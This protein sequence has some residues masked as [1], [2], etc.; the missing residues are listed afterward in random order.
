MTE[1]ECKKNYLKK[2]IDYEKAEKRIEFQIEELRR[3]KMNPSLNIDGMP[4]GSNTRDLSDYISELDG[5]ERTLL[6]ARCEKIAVYTEIFTQI[7]MLNNEKE[8][9]VLTFRYI[10]NYKWERIACEMGYSNRQVSRIHDIAIRH[11]NIK[12][13]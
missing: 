9:S 2:Y 5:L 13:S 1:N 6:N 11:F 10:N 4:H 3:N 8:R 12:M 7:E